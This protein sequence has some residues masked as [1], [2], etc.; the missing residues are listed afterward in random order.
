MSS[1]GLYLITM[2]ICLSVYDATAGVTP[3]DGW[4][5]STG[6][7]STEVHII[8]ATIKHS[9]VDDCSNVLT[10]NARVYNTIAL[11]AELL[12]HTNATM[13]SPNCPY[14]VTAIRGQQMMSGRHLPCLLLQ[15]SSTVGD[16]LAK[17]QTAGRTDT[18]A[19]DA[20]KLGSL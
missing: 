16:H 18:G 19:C 4:V 10:Q 2:T 7:I 8:M 20:T 3:F 6:V 11:Y 13:K 5:H 12:T 9:S 15:P 17:R 1:A 14:A